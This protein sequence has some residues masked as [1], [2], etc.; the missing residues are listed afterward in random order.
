MAEYQP[1]PAGRC[2]HP[3]REDLQRLM[4]G[5][6]SREGAKAVVRH[7]L[8]GCQ[9]CARETRRIWSF[10]EERLQPV[11]IR[12]TRPPRQAGVWL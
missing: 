4:A 1:Q 2:T 8:S 12:T 10:G 9:I 11:T 6:L 3:A 7:L 5:E